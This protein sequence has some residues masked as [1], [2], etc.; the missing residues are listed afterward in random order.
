MKTPVSNHECIRLGSMSYVLVANPEFKK[1][2][3]P[4]RVADADFSNIPAIVFNDR[5]DLQSAY[6]KK[7]FHFTGSYPTTSIPSTSG[8]KAAIIAGF[9]YG[10]Q[11]VID[12]QKELKSKVLVLV[13]PEKFERELYIHHWNYQSATLKKLIASIQSAS[14]AII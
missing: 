11:P 8:N 12:I 4:K 9:G 3:F 7:H 1:K 10:L 6:L 14:K 5:D 13:S 2:H